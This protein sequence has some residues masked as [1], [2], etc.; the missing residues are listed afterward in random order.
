L[1][2]RDSCFLKA[3]AFTECFNHQLNYM[4]VQYEAIIKELNRLEREEGEELATS[5]IL[6]EGAFLLDGYNN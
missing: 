5:L 2:D 4:K 3:V 6:P 1:I